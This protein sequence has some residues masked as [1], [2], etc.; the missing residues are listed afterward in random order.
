MTFKECERKGVFMFNF[1]SIIVGIAAW[2]LGCWAA[3]SKASRTSYGLSVASFVSCVVALIS[4]L[5]EIGRRV[6]ISDFAAVEDTIRA[7]IIAAIV[8]TVV[9]VVLNVVAFVRN[10]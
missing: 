7:V 9:T 3:A 4:Q 8:L 10:K 5:L 1:I 2:V 6:A